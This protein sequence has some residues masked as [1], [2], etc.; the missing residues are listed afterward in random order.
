[1]VGRFDQWYLEGWITMRVAFI[2]EHASPAALLGGEDAGG[3]NV[4]V[5]EVARH[6]GQLGFE[7]DI[8]TR[9]DSPSQDLNVS[10][11]HGVRIINLPVGPPRH[12]PKDEL[13]PLMTGFRDQ[14]LRFIIQDGARYQVIHGNFWMSGWVAA[15]L[16]NK[17]GVPAV[18]LFHALGTTKRRHQGRADSSPPGR[19]AVERAIMQRV[20]RVIA[21]CPNER[22]EL[23]EDYGASPS[24]IECIPL[25]VDTSRFHP[26]NR[27]EARRRMGLGLADDDI[28]LVYVGRLL[29]RKDIRCI[30][31]ALAQMGDIRDV[32]AERIKLLI[33]GGESRQPDPLITPEIGE[34]RQL[35]SELGV[36]ERVILV[37]K[38]DQDELRDY[39]SAG[40]V[41]VTTPWYEPF[42]LTPLEA[43]ACGRPVVGAD[44]GGISFT[45]LH[46]QTGLLA[47]PRSPASLAEALRGLLSDPSRYEK[48]GAAGRRR[49]LREFRWSV[50]AERTAAL[51]QEVNAATTNLPSETPVA[52]AISGL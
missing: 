10:W 51:Y 16:R 7:V 38:R 5:D 29:P 4:Y 22:R 24:R 48:M 39:Y 36:S 28:V 3:Q 19:I 33:V 37:G 2:S 47:P 26:V 40:D 35:A 31:R 17:L 52:R 43:M 14:L 21:S 18:Q 27:L 30:V 41:M 50:V 25:G 42:G 20:D 23:I 46:G 44:V 11:A 32:P 9:R 34:L 6:L 15:E 1:M 12:V 49:V 8:F 13:W 45:V